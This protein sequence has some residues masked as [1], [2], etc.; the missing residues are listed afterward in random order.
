MLARVAA[1][2]IGRLLRPGLGAHLGA[3]NLVTHRAPVVS[4][5][6]FSRVGTNIQ[7]C[8]RPA[9]PLRLPSCLAAGDLQIR[10][11]RHRMM[12]KRDNPSNPKRFRFSTHLFFE[13]C[14]GPHHPL[15]NCRRRLMRNQVTDLI[16][17][18][19]IQTT[20]HKAKSVLCFSAISELNSSL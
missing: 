14:N 18:E 8:L 4:T 3:R 9:M 13:S 6:L 10:E 16:K 7:S 2:A 11:M 5:M 1:A 12:K 17:H 19:R 15:C 20:L